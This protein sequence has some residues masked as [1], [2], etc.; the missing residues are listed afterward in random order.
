MISAPSMDSCRLRRC[1]LEMSSIDW[2]WNFLRISLARG[3]FGTF[4]GLSTLYENSE[5]CS[6]KDFLRILT[7]FLRKSIPFSVSVFILSCKLPLFSDDIW[8]TDLSRKTSNFSADFRLFG[9]LLAEG[10]LWNILEV[11]KFIKLTWN[12]V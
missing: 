9:T 4:F 7:I 12:F 5:I 2:D 3:D 1:C 10:G 8:S 6:K 11:L